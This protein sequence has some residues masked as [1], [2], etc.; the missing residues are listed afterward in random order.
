MC[1]VCHFVL[2]HRAQESA[3][4]G[5]SGVGETHD[6]IDAEDAESD[7]TEGSERMKA[8]RGLCS[9]SEPEADSDDDDDDPDDSWLFLSDASSDEEP[10]EPDL[11]EPNAAGYLYTDPDNL[12]TRFARIT[13][14]RGQKCCRCYKHVNCS[15]I[16]PRMSLV[17]TEAM[18]SWA[19]AGLRPEV[20]TRENHLGM[21]PEFALDH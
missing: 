20:A 2:K 10:P 18:I 3:L 4:F 5:S 21:R 8:A 17:T 9:E 7:G 6:A 16:I 19:L 13:E 11:P 1:L 15:W 14:F 12:R